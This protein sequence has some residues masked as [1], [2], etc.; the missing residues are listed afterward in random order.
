MEHNG[1]AWSQTSVH[2]RFLLYHVIG[3]EGIGIVLQVT[4]FSAGF[5]A[6]DSGL[7]GCAH[8]PAFVECPIEMP[9]LPSHMGKRAET[10]ICAYT[11]TYG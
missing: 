2:T 6:I 3:K 5:S 8:Q 1:S 9:S 10:C 7:S 4:G 11:Y